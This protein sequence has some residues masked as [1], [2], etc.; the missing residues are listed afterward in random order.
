MFPAEIE[1]S[2]AERWILIGWLFVLGGAF[3]SFMNVV[4]YR[5]P[6]KMSLLYPPSR[7][8]ACGH[9]IR[10]HDNVPIFGWVRLRGHCRDCGV[11]ISPRYPLV[12]LLVAATSA[13]LAWKIAVPGLVSSPA[14]A[15]QIFTFDFAA[16]AYRFLLSYMLICCA[17]LEFDGQR[18]RHWLLWGPLAIGLAM[19]L[20]WPH[21]APA[22]DLV[23]ID[24]PLAGMFA[25]ALGIASA[26]LV[27]AGLWFTWVVSRQPASG[28]YATTALATLILVG[29]F[30]GVQ[31]VCTI[32][33]TAGFVYLATQ[34]LARKWPAASRFGWAGPLTLVTLVWVL[35]WPSSRGLDPTLT[36]APS[37]RLILATC[38]MIIIATVLQI[39]PLRSRTTWTGS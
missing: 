1:F 26:V 37:T 8:P 16:Y 13:M 30:L 18:P 10:W 7:C 9:P 15:G 36:L 3:G 35:A 2:D 32:A 5:A 11:A 6:R 24:G 39:A 27:G 17:L 38:V 12:E 25:V 21:L 14:D 22:N 19:V 29:S 33:P 4:V 31:A 20:L 28:R 23:P 34:L